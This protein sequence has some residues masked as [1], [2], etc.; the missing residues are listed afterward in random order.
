MQFDREWFDKQFSSENQIRFSRVLDYSLSSWMQNI[1]WAKFFSLLQRVPQRNSLYV[2]FS[3]LLLPF[4]SKKICRFIYAKKNKFR[5]EV[6]N[7]ISCER[8]LNS[9]MHF[10]NYAIR[11]ILFFFFLLFL[12]F[13]LLLFALLVDLFRLHSLF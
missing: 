11:S 13:F 8:L 9:K 6:F 2:F 5:Q 7:G 1:S 10:M 3:P 4:Y 12:F